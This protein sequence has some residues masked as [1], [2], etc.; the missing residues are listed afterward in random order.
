MERYFDVCVDCRKNSKTFG[1]FFS[2]DLSDKDKN[3][4]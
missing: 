1:K 3:Q 2:I 4:F